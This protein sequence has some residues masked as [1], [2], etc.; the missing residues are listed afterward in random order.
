MKTT[1]TWKP[2]PAK[3][4]QH[5]YMISDDGVI[6]SNTQ[7]LPAKN[8]MKRLRIG[9]P[10]KTFI[11]KRSGYPF[12]KL[13]KDGK[14]YSFYIHRLVAE[15]FTDNPENK[16]YVNHIN[17]DKLDYSLGNL[18]WVTASE[19]RNHA[20]ETGLCKSAYLKTKVINI[21]TGEEY[22][23]IPVAAEVYKHRYV[24]LQRMLRGQVVNDTCLRLAHPDTAAS[25]LRVCR[26]YW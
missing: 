10:I 22:E 3:G 6:M 13:S 18:E 23:S 1:I 26:W 24:N 19:N 5:L 4:L 21:C 7:T 25:F 20:L 12:V 8:G 9:R 16:P 11:D 2:V 17:G 15:A 14:D